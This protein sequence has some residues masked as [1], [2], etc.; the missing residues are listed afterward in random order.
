MSCRGATLESVAEGHRDDVGG[1]VLDVVAEPDRADAGDEGIQLVF[2]GAG[3]Y[4]YE[5][6]LR[7]A[8]AW[9]PDQL[10]VRLG[11]DEGLARR[12]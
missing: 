6:M 12:I 3:E 7:G 4:R 5:E 1:I 10:A 8:A 9:K 11:Y 2:L